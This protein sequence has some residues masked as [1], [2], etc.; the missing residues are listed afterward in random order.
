MKIAGKEV[1][2]QK[3]IECTNFYMGSHFSAAFSNYKD[4]LENWIL[5]G[6]QEF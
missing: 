2:F 1:N 6:R 4:I 3:D 5:L